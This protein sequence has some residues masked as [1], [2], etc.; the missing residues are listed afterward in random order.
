MQS[1][2]VRVLVVAIAAAML[3]GVAFATERSPARRADAV[4]TACVKKKGQMRLVRNAAACTRRESVVTWNVM[5]P[6]GDPGPAGPAGDRGPSGAVGPPGPAGPVGPVGAQG[7]TGAVGPAGSPGPA[8]PQGPAG[9]AGAR[10]DD[11]AP[12]A[13]GPA[14][15]AGPQGPKGDPG[16]GGLTSFGD[17]EGLACSNG[18]LGGTIQIS[19]DAAGHAT[20]TCTT[21]TPPPPPPPPSSEPVRVNEV[22]TGTSGAAADEFVE[23]YNPGTADVDIGGWKVVYRSAAGTSDTTLATIPAGATIAAGGF[24]LLGGSGYA[25]TATVDQ[26]FSTGLAATGGGVGVRDST[27]APVDSVGWGTATN[28]LVEGSAAPAPP[29]TATPGSSIVRLPDGHDTDAN[30]A[31]FTITATATPKASNQ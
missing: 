14:G 10:G 19:F 4:I 25:G 17:L 24:Y 15:P 1:T 20:L 27:G 28:E 31:D 3:A 13:A 26:S 21:T 22:Q 7:A 18:G 29:A 30:A 8:G 23:L 2:L 11:G 9:P 16:G 5:G 12:G 6:K